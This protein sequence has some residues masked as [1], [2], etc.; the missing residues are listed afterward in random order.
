METEEYASITALFSQGFHQER[1]KS[2]EFKGRI[3]DPGTDR[4]WKTDIKG[5]EK[6]EKSNRL[7]S[8]GKTLKFIRLIS[9]FPIFELS[10]V[11]EDTWVPVMLV[12]KSLCSSDIE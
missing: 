11:W 9:D 3:F 8:H 10:N 7:A 6:L 12:R 1:S 4:Q 5:L 2:F